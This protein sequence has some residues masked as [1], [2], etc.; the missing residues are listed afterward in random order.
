MRKITV[1]VSDEVFERLKKIKQASGYVNW[2]KFFIGSVLWG[3]TY[4]GLVVRRRSAS[5]P[6]D[7]QILQK[8]LARQ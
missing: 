8:E 2:R 1:E 6:L 3:C 7:I 5:L 4:D